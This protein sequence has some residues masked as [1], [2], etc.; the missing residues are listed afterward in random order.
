[1]FEETLVKGAKD[2][3]AALGRSDILKGTYLAG[4]TAAA[5][6]LGHRV[7]VDFDFFT[8]KELIPK[9]FSANLSKLGSFRVEQADKGTVL[10]V[11]EGVKF[12]LFSYKYPLVFPVVKYQ[13][14]R[15]ADI[16]D[17]AAMKIDA[18]AS[19]GA[20]RDF[21]DL[22][23]ICAAGFTLRDI[24][25]IYYKKYGKAA[26]GNIIHIQKSLVFFND[27]EPEKMPRMLRRAEWGDV[28]RYFET[29]VKKLAGLI[30][31][32]KDQ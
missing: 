31:N 1:M 13:A 10:G 8:S 22:Y 18:I 21:V 23:F 30:G 17:I 25:K 6:Q 2:I 5:L 9:V 29:E 32:N 12:S 4:G 27:A 28:K 14:L 24:L 3:L 26:A 7:S 11:F 15:I 19:R 16:R 20:K